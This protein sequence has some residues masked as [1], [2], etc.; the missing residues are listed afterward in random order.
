MEWKVIWNYHIWYICSFLGMSLFFLEKKAQCQWFIGSFSLLKMIKWPWR[1]GVNVVGI[2]WRFEVFMGTWETSNMCHRTKS[3]RHC[4]PFSSSLERVQFLGRRNPSIHMYSRHFTVFCTPL[5]KV[6]MLCS[7]NQIVKL[8]PFGT[9][10]IRNHGS[11][12]KQSLAQNTTYI[13]ILES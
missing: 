6:L 13:Y 10:C 7:Q 1:G 12:K 3:P 8:L 4:V 5:W 9:F 11:D 2:P